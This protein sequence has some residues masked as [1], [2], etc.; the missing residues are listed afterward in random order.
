M[1]HLLSKSSLGIMAAGAATLYQP[2]P[3]PGPPADGVA[4]RRD[5][6]HVT[7]PVMKCALCS[8][9]DVLRPAVRASRTGAGGGSAGRAATF[10][11]RAGQ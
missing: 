1:L 6:G 8:R 7:S 5:R 10:P 2:P 11:R 4:G 9:R 3:P